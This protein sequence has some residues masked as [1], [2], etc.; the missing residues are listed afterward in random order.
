MQKNIRPAKMALLNIEHLLYGKIEK[1][2]HEWIR[3]P[4]A[5][6]KT[7]NKGDMWFIGAVVET[8]LYWQDITERVSSFK[9]RGTNG[10]I[11]WLDILP[12]NKSIV[13][14]HGKPRIKE[15]AS[16]VDWVAKYIEDDK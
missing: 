14:F 9:P 5:H 11:E 8:D 15:A 2:W 16:I 3:H 1:I 13:C 10:K 6:M 4:E 7:H 12:E